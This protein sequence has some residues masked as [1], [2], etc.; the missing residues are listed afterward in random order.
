LYKGPLKETLANNS[1]ILDVPFLEGPL[2]TK[3]S[4]TLLVKI[5]TDSGVF[6][7]PV[8]SF[9]QNSWDAYEKDTTVWQESVNSDITK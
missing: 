7:S 2:R 8:S 5:E 4:G 3:S 9:S 6:V 1:K